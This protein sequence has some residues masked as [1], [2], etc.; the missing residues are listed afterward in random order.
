YSAS[1]PLPCQ[2][3]SGQKAKCSAAR[4]SADCSSGGGFPTVTSRVSKPISTTRA[5]HRSSHDRRTAD[6]R[7][8]S[9]CTLAAPN[10]PIAAIVSAGLLAAISATRRDLSWPSTSLSSFGSRDLLNNRPNPDG[11]ATA[12]ATASPGKSMPNGSTEASDSSSSS[13]KQFLQ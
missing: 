6:I 2:I 3:L 10:H 13:S 4:A 12:G 11:G 5:C 1:E 8:G 9:S 7:A